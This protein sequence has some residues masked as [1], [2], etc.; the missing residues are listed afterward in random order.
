VTALGKVAETPSRASGELG[1]RRRECGVD[2]SRPIA[3][4]LGGDGSTLML[5]GRVRGSG[6]PEQSLFK[7]KRMRK[8]E[9]RDPHKRIAL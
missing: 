5:A 6:S 3:A 7:G 2:G 4:S 1:P 8:T 9:E